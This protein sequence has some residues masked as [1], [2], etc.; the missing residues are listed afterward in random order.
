MKRAFTLIELIAVIVILG[1]VATMGTSLLLNIYQ[2]YSQSQNLSQ[3]QSQTQTSV[4]QIAKLLSYRVK[5]SVIA[6]VANT[7]DFKKL[8]DNQ[9]ERYNV[10]EFISYEPDLFND[11]FY[12]GVVD[13]DASDSGI[14]ITPDSSLTEPKKYKEDDD[15]EVSLTLEEAITD[16]LENFNNDNYELALIFKQVPYDTQK[17]F[18]YDENFAKHS[19]NETIARAKIA[20]N[21]K[22]QIKDYIQKQISEHYQLAYTAHA[23]TLVKNDNG[24]FNLVIY[25]N[26]RPWLNERYDK[27]AKS[28]ILAKNVT[29]FNFKQESDIIY[30]RLCLKNDSNSIVCKLKAVY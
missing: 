2:S 30:L 22:F 18:G 3:L 8:D 23:I 6:R 4:N 27:D 21:E 13:L 7:N 20:D 17:A 25:Y 16:D 10:L 12:S 11:D 14:I 29:A 15:Q 9:D 24:E 5:P 19:P 26:Y 1:I 28:S